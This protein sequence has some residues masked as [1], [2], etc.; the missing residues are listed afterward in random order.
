MVLT[1]SPQ[2][3]N[4]FSTFNIFD[5]VAHGYR[6]EP[7]VGGVTANS[8]QGNEFRRNRNLPHST[9]SRTDSSTPRLPDTSTPSILPPCESLR[10]SGVDFH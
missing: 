3:F 5:P 6:A 9:N 8:R 7:S 2:T 4:T 10:A 1:L